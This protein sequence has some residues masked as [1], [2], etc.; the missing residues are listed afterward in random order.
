MS[1]SALVFAIL[2]VLL[3]GGAQLLLRQ[4]ALGDAEP[5]RPL[6]LLKSG[7]FMGG[8]ASYG[9]SVLTWLAVLKSTPLAVATPFVA[10]VY[11]AVPLA[12]RYVFGD[13][14]SPRMWIGMA[15]VVVGVSLVASGH[16]TG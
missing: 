7:W 1:R 13:A 14:I 2:T 4:A 6:S 5:A 12:S 8:V 9:I 11:V 3:N 15:L 10:I 16:P